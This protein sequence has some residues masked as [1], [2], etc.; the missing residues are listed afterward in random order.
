M[1]LL[2]L[3][4]KQNLKVKDSKILQKRGA[5]KNKKK[6]KNNLNYRNK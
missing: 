2:T 4:K 1:I 5:R 6:K 3:K